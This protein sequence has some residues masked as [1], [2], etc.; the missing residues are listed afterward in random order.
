MTLSAAGSVETAYADAR[1]TER[2]QRSR[3]AGRA[4]KLGLSIECGSGQS[5]GDRRLRE[6]QSE[7]SHS[8]GRQ[9]AVG[10]ILEYPVSRGLRCRPF[11]WSRTLHRG[12]RGPG[13]LEA[14]GAVRK[15]RAL[16][17]GEAVGGLRIGT[18]GCAEAQLRVTEHRIS[19]EG[20]MRRIRVLG[21]PNGE[22]GCGRR[23]DWGYRRSGESC[24]Q[25][26]GPHHRE[27]PLLGS[28][29][30]SLSTKSCNRNQ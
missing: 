23:G 20:Q 10:A 16:P 28:Y 22:E 14:Q 12:L 19:N 29:D 3:P 18:P 15:P 7:S 17:G 4:P 11:R 30:Q 27:A 8:F 9:R 5:D 1:R 2:Q 24:R 13:E 25:S 6:R 21:S 26:A